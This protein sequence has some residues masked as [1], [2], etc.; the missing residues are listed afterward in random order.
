[1]N[2]V[3]CVYN[4]RSITMRNVQGIIQNMAIFIA[5]SSIFLAP[6][7]SFA[8]TNTSRA[9]LQAQI[10]SLLEQISYLEQLLAKRAQAESAPLYKTNFYDTDFEAIYQVSPYGLHRID[11]RTA[12]YSQHRALWELFTDTVGKEAAYTYIGEFRVFNEP[13]SAYGAFVE[14]KPHEINEPVTWVLA[15]NESG[16]SQNKAVMQNLIADLYIHEYAHILLHNM[17]GFA[18]D[19]E[20]SFWQATDYTHAAEVAVANSVQSERLLETYY[21]ANKERFVSD[22]ATTNVEEDI[23]ETFAVFVETDSADLDSEVRGAK[24]RMFYTNQ[25]FVSARETIR[26]NLSID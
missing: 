3:I 2:N 20:V 17:P 16:Y 14:A 9:E 23:A 19:F 18:Q 5:F 1:M 25:A 7:I 13:N 4:I 11:E 10:T 26:E 8:V 22:Y 12:V 6:S 21:N 15:V 24:V